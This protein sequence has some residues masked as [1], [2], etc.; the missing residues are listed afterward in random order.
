MD[1]WLLAIRTFETWGIV[2]R[3]MASSSEDG[4]TAE[5]NWASLAALCVVAGV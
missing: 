1:I 4:A 2:G 5:L 3:A